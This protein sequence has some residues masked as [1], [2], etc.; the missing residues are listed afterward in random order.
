M[1][2]ILFW[3]LVSSLA[4]LC[5]FHTH[6]QEIISTDVSDGTHG[7]F[8][9]TNKYSNGNTSTIMYVPCSC[10]GTLRCAS[11]GG[12]G[13]L[14]GGWQC[15]FCNGTGRCFCTKY[16]Y[17]GYTIASYAIFDQFGNCLSQESI[18]GDSPSS[19]QSNG[20]RNSNRST[21]SNCHV[22]GGTGID[23]QPCDTGAGNWIGYYNPSGTKCPY[24]GR[25]SSHRHNK[26][27]HCNVPR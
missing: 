4:F 7:N 16:D 3:F 21:S 23:P 12:T 10:R 27:Y 14:Y 8:F 15:M 26:C 19:S 9:V 22:C 25:Y 17:P 13:V 2:K 24:C 5:T 1:G 11:C 18:Y 20:H 6:A